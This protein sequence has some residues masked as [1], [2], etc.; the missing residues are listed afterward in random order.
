MNWL[1]QLLKRLWEEIFGQS[2]PAY[3][4]YL[5]ESDLPQKLK[6]QA[7]YIVHENGYFEHASMICPCGCG[8]TLHMNLIPDEHP[9]W[10]FIQHSDDTISLHP[11]VWRMKGCRSHFFFR[12]C[13]ILW[14]HEELAT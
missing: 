9:Y 11:S 8:E 4:H 13:K 6:K 3:Q 14:V 12:H 10:K 2:Q 7:I 5:V 1:V